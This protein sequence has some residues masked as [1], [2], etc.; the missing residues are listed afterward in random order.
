MNIPSAHVKQVYKDCQN[1]SRYTLIDIRNLEERQN[2][3][4]QQSIAIAA[5]ELLQHAKDNF[6]KDHTY[7]IICQKGISSAT[8][9]QSLIRNGIDNAANVDKGF[10]HWQKNQLPI[11]RPSINNHDL[12]YARHYQLQGFGK[13]AQE[14][15]TNSH[16]LLIGAGGLG[17][18]SALYLA[19]AGIGSMTII[20]DDV[21]QLSNL[22]R[23][24][25]HTTES[26][27]TLKVDSAKQRM[28]AINPEINI[29]TVD[30]RLNANNA[31]SL[32]KRADV[33]ID[34][35]DNL[36]T[37]YLVNDLCLKHKKPLVYAAVYQ[38][39][40]QISVFDMRLESSPC[41][42]CLFPYTEGFEP[43]NCSTEGVLG[44]V[45]GFAGILQ[46]TET[47]KLITKVGETLQ[48][49]LLICN[50]LDNSFRTIK[51]KKDK[52]CKLH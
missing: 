8:A 33:I 32:I 21:V 10:E 39:E 13:Q 11:K 50:L 22:Q 48:S 38:F 19:A 27:D 41:M 49:K 3:V 5:H 37:R 6:I 34:G 1:S 47:I 16:V 17:S 28:Q 15:L 31:E 29:N 36:K 25:I 35:T 42:R 9:V 14:K 44:V 18:S 23:Q 43:A 52:S 40:A 30:E 4:V 12:R 26:I 7:Y 2:G 24:I 45:P 51:Y 46:A 20:D